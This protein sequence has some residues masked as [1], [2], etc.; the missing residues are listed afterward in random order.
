MTPTT[1]KAC[2]IGWPINHSRSPL[3]HGYWLR[4][5]GIDGSYERVPVEPQSLKTFVNAMRSGAYVGCNVTLPH[6]EAMA[7]LVDHVDERAARVKS[8]NTVYKRQG[9]L[10]ATS[11]DGAGFCRNVIDYTPTF[12]FEDARVVM[13]GAGGS[14]RAIID[15]LLRRNVKEVIIVN[16]SVDRA[17]LLAD[18]FGN[19]VKPV[20][21]KDLPRHAATCGLLVN[22][23]SLGMTGQPPL[24][25]DLG[26]FPTTTVVADIIYTPLRTELIR[27]AE[28]RGHVAVPGL[29]MLLHQAVKGFELWFSATPEVTPELH[30][31]VARDIDPEFKP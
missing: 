9:K 6:K 10:H 19:R 30:D 27:R 5:F 31:L 23:T 13:F 26:P 3:I 8:V 21:Q 14:A 17:R 18:V 28:Q 4:Q 24:D 15:E 2:V 29:G 1:T 16:R 22:T 25:L 20:A 12:S 11:T 7:A